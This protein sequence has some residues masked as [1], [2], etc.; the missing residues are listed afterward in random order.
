MTQKY[1]NEKGIERALHYFGSAQNW[2]QRINVHKSIISKVINNK[3]EISYKNAIFT[4]LES[5]NYILAS[6][7]RTDMPYFII[8][9]S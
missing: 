2:S 1:T 4:Q 8:S 9:N 7:L 3:I 6:H 5:D